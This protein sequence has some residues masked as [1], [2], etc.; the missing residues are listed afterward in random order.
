MIGIDANIL[1]YAYVEKAP[2]HA[3]ARAFLEKHVNDEDIA[4]SEFALAELYLLLRNPS[5][6]EKPLT[7][8]AASQVIQTYRHH[9]RWKIPGFPLPAALFTIS[10]GPWLNRLSLRAGDS[11]MH[12]QHLL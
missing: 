12:A 3:R 6:L 10:S 1:L 2:E 7:A 11:L 4:V 9:P 8:A 5:V